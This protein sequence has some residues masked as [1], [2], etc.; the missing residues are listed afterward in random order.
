MGHGPTNAAQWL[1]TAVGQGAMNNQST[2]VQTYGNSAFGT[3]SLLSNVVGRG[4]VA[5]GTHAMEFCLGGSNIGVGYKALR[6]AN[7]GSPETGLST[8]T[9]VNNVGIGIGAMY[10][11]ESGN[12]NAALGANALWSNH[13]GNDNTALG[14]YS[15]VNLNGGINNVAIGSGSLSS[16]TGSGVSCTNNV[17]IGYGAQ[18]PSA[19]GANQLSI[20]NIIFGKSMNSITLASI[21]IG[22]FP[23]T[24]TNNSVY[25]NAFAKLDV[26]G[27]LRIRRIDN[28][29][30]PPNN[31]YLF[32]DADGMI[33]QSTLPVINGGITSVVNTY[34][35]SNG[36][37]ITAVNNV[38]SNP[39]T[40]ANLYNID[41][42]LFTDRKVTMNDKN[43]WFNTTGSSA[44][45][46][47]IYIGDNPLYPISSGPYKLYVEGGIL[48][49][50]V[51]VALRN[52]DTNWADYVFED[53]YNLMPLKNVEAFIKSNK[54]LPG[55][56]TAEE[57]IKNGLDIA[58]MQSKQMAKIE[59]LTLYIIQQS[60]EIETLKT[61][62]ETLLRK[63]K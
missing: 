14:N 5:I 57:I 3:N 45:K 47:K 6:G 13:N 27:T 4:N 55:I 58:E 35:P 11:T 12:N 52:P 20:Q 7:V 8:N 60:K 40:I 56:E 19:T 21:G 31:N 38:V 33:A 51:K 10:N 16:L 32:V 23:N 24:T 46:G 22:V 29:T 39:V 44:A 15:L 28:I 36:I 63:S 17:G 50:K 2:T 49:E 26:N 34:T 48:T 61:K 18:V 1:N 54:H 43:L 59:E 41:G 30:T 42:N 53:T 37:L 25:P 62:V 9:G